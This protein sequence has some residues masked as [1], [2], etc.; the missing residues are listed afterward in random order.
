MATESFLRRWQ[1]AQKNIF[2]YCKLLNFKPSW[3]Q[4]E[5]LFIVQ[6]EADSPSEKRLKR[7]AIK[8]GQGPGKTKTASVIGSWRAMR[9]LDAVTIITAPTLR[10]VRDIYMAELRRVVQKADPELQQ[11]YNITAFRL[12]IGGRQDWGIRAVTSNKPENVQGNHQKRMSFVFDE[13]SGIPRPIWETVKAGLTNED[14]FLL[15]I[16]N[17]ND[18]DTGFHDCFYANAEEW[19]RLTWNAEQS[20]DYIVDKKNL[21]K[22]EK[23][24]GRESD[25]YRVRVLGEFP[26]QDPSSIMSFEDLLECTKTRMDVLAR[27]RLGEG[28]IQKAFGIDLARKG[29][30]ES[31]IAVRVGK[32]L[33]K[34]VVFLNREP[35]DVIKHAMLLQHELGWKDGECVYVVDASGIGQGVLHS[36]YE[37]RKNVHE[38]F[39]NGT[40]MQPQKYKDKASE[41]HFEL[42][43]LV[44]ERQAHLPADRLM[45]SQLSRRKYDLKKGLIIIESKDDFKARIGTEES[46]S[47]DR[48]DGVVMAFYPFVS[49]V[50]RITKPLTVAQQL[51]QRM[52]GR[53]NGDEM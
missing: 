26:R 21:R 34:L 40:P 13:A 51:G 36:L 50:A 2:D 6:K 12:V 4:E 8:S 23:E 11:I 5:A 3:Q 25:V 15:A 19:H 14:S 42:R 44:K 28:S 37:N 48:A 10:Q 30:D 35:I 45:L 22:I 39:S 32:A 20:P 52:L 49:A 47:P 33:I 31:V 41:A 24:Y 43:A 9:F 16:G 29:G 53:L 38:F 18:I 1:Q 17:P 46:L 7:L 27:E